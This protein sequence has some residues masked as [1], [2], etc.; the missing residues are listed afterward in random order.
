MSRNNDLEAGSAL[1]RMWE[2]FKSINFSSQK[3]EV[4]ELQSLCGVF[5]T[6]GLLTVE[7]SARHGGVIQVRGSDSC[8]EIL[9]ATILA[10]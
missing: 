7:N 6:A 1:Y 9:K 2:S 4:E 10:P 8:W 5:S 3:K